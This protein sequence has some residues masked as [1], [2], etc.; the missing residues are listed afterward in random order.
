MHNT[1]E[2]KE[3]NK[4]YTIFLEE[5][6]SSDGLELKDKAKILNSGPHR[7]FNHMSMPICNS[8]V[9]ECRYKV[10]Q[11]AHTL[12]SLKHKLQTLNT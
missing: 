10:T 6:I 3:E 5:H 12:D 1:E 11:H 2:N 9:A 8:T 4:L 7:N